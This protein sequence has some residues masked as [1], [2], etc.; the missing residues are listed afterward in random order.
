VLRTLVAGRHDHTDHL[1][2]ESKV[3]PKPGSRSPKISALPKAALQ[4]L[5]N[6]GSC[7][8]PV[9]SEVPQKIA[10]VNAVSGFKALH[11]VGYRLL[12]RCTH[13]EKHS[14]TH[15]HQAPLLLIVNTLPY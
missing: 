6:L 7:E 8:R 2:I 13:P 10:E 5:K 12:A 14:K 11:P 4:M 15:F 9:D 3:N 1:A